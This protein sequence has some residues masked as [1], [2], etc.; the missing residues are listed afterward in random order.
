MTVK[1]KSRKL[2][3]I[4][5][6]IYLVIEII[7]WAVSAFSTGYWFLPYY[8]VWIPPIILAVG[9]FIGDERI[10]N[11]V[12][13][14]AFL[15]ACLFELCN[16]IEPMA[17]HDN[18]TRFL[19]AFMLVIYGLVGCAFVSCKRNRAVRIAA[20]VALLALAMLSI[21]G[22]R[23]DYI[24]HVVFPSFPADLWFSNDLDNLIVF[25]G[26]ETVTVLLELAGGG[27][28]VPDRGAGQEAPSA[29]KQS[30]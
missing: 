4:L 27:L 9:Y 19:A 3:G 10:H 7:A 29:E 24:L 22:D 13:T 30:A 6:A 26:I 18:R 28:P 12:T 16:V 21:C 8:A 14:I 1:L 2:F 20:S 17:S 25:G 23:I 11:T 15:S 5:L